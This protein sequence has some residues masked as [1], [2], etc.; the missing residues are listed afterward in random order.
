MSGVQS[1]LEPLGYPHCLQ[2][3]LQWYLQVPALIL[4]YSI[5]GRTHIWI[6]LV[7]HYWISL[8]ALITGFLGP[9]FWI[10]GQFS[11]NWISVIMK[12]N[13]ALTLEVCLEN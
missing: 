3:C 9:H 1:G 7:A 4:G 8:V 12:F 11:G 10:Y 5:F 6:S 2:C 13:R